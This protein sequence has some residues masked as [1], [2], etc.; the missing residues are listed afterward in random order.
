MAKSF[1][2]CTVKSFYEDSFMVPIQQSLIEHEGE[3]EIKIT[4]T[5]NMIGNMACYECNYD[6]K[7]KVFGKVYNKNFNYYFVQKKFKL[8]YDK[9]NK[10]CLVAIKA[11]LAHEYIDFLNKFGSYS[12]HPIE[13]DYTYMEPLIDEITAAWI[14][15]LKTTHVKTKGLYGNKVNKSEEFKEAILDGELSAMNIKFIAHSGEEHLIGINKSGSIVLYDSFKTIES[16]IE[17]VIA[18]YNKLIKKPA[19]QQATIISIV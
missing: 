12:L 19:I 17:L 1:L 15:G 13:M 6:K 7:V 2:I 18:L 16:E 10:L 9:L 5:D 11:E 3:P 4:S 8:Y 14:S